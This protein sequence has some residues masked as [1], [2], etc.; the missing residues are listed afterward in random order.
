MTRGWVT[1]HFD[2]VDQFSAAARP[3]DRRAYTHKLDF[4]LDTAFHVFNGLPKGRWLR[5]VEFETSLDFLA[6]GRPKAGDVF[7][8]G[9]RY[10]DSASP[11][12]ASCLVIIP[13]APF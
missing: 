3:H 10:L 1:S 2:V 11:W 9:S 7:P 8:D 13:I 12:S 5:G 4:E 6:T